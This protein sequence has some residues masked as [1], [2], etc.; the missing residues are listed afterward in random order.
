MDVASVY[1]PGLFVGRGARV[2]PIRVYKNIYT[3]MF[4]PGKVATT[5]ILYPHDNASARALPIPGSRGN[6]GGLSAFLCGYYQQFVPTEQ[7]FNVGS[8]NC[9]PEV[10][11]GV[12]LTDGDGGHYK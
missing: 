8:D 6:S 5:S 2:Q 11:R 3:C 10:N 1:R 12:V 4:W 9:Q 7:L